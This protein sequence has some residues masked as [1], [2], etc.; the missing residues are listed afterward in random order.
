MDNRIRVLV[1][2]DHPIVRAGLT[3]LLGAQ[4]DLEVVGQAADGKEALLLVD[5]LRPDVVVI[6]LSMPGLSGIETTRQI[7]RMEP[8]IA[9]VM[10][11]MH[12]KEAYV[13]QALEA[14]AAAYVLKGAENSEII[15][16]VHAARRNEYYL[17][18][19]ISKGVI[20]SFL[21]NSRGEPKVEPYDLLSEREQQIFRLLVEG[22]STVRIADLLCV[23]PKTVEKHR[24]NTMKK[25]ECT[26]LLGLVRY[27]VKVGVLD[28]DAWKD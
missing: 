2:D 3:S 19:R 14:G 17:C 9:V 20:D 13:L 26:D 28:A 8:Q 22:N 10:L 12:D 24:S 4:A 27:A 21:K 18:S 7:R 1:T 5:R 25:L 23:S 6:D 11:S 16:A 15:R